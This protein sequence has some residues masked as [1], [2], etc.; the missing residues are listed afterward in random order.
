MIAPFWTFP[1]HV[2]R[3]VIRRERWRRL[4]RAHRGRRHAV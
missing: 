1:L 3:T 2:F 4:Q